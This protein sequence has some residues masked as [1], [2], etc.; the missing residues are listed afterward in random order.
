MRKREI[1]R[2][3]GGYIQRRDMHYIRSFQFLAK[4]TLV[5]KANPGRDES[6]SVQLHQIDWVVREFCGT[7]EEPVEHET[8]TALVSDIYLYSSKDGMM[9]AQ[10]LKGKLESYMFIYTLWVCV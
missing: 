6:S 10:V 3:R 8:G 7:L 5:W 2:E 1:E 4:R 9:S